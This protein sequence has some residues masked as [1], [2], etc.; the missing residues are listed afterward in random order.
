M[1]FFFLCGS[2]AKQ[3]F[4]FFLKCVIVRN[5]RTLVQSGVSA[6]ILDKA[7]L[8]TIAFV[9]SVQMSMH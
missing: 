4:F 7:V 8:P 9:P 1:L 6:L 2:L 3:T 5:T